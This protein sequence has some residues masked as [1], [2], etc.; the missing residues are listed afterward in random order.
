VPQDDGWDVAERETLLARIAERR[1]FLDF[2]FHRTRPDGSRQEFRVSG[3]P[4]FDQSCRFV[5]YRGV[6][7]EV[8]SG[9]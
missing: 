5:G 8:T 1:P 6:G 3:E 2:A 7:M 9:R 4:M